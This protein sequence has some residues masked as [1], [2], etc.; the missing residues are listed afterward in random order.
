M[1][2]AGALQTYLALVKKKYQQWKGSS[3][4]TSGVKDDT[5]DF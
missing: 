2:V 3:Q 4:E 5:Q 1:L